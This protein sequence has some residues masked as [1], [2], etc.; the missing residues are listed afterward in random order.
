MAQIAISPRAILS[1]LLTS[2]LLLLTLCIP[3]LTLATNDATWATAVQKGTKLFQLL[4]SGCYPDKV[5]PLS[6]ESLMALGWRVGVG[7]EPDQN[8]PPK[9]HKD[10]HFSQREQK[11]FKWSERADAYWST[12]VNHF[13]KAS[14]FLPLLTYL[15]IL[16]LNF[17]NLAAPCRT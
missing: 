17:S 1:L 15:R 13:S 4:Q 2:V 7:S 9:F 12:T 11:F 5:N 16:L 10:S 14:L 3:Y 6:R 8:W